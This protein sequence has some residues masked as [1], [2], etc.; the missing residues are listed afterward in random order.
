M[1]R[2]RRNIVNAVDDSPAGMPFGCAVAGPVI[3]DDS[4]SNV[5]VLALVEVPVEAAAGSAVQRKDRKACRIAPLSECERA[6][7]SRGRDFSACDHAWGSYASGVGVSFHDARVESP[8][9][10][11]PTA[12]PPSD[13]EP[14][15]RIGLLWERA[16]ETWA[17][18]VH[19]TRPR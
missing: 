13:R 6:P 2:D 3:G 19:D 5:H 15:G 1:I 10:A 11:A 9:V 8:R 12:L 16:P 7:V 17:R 18:A 4:G 14:K